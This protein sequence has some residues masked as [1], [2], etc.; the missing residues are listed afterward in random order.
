MNHLYDSR[1]VTIQDYR[2]IMND[3]LSTDKQ[4]EKRIQYLD[5]F[6]RNIIKAELS[7]FLAKN[8]KQKILAK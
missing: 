2:K 7:K 3:E 5:A 4:I 6:C 8:K 1:T